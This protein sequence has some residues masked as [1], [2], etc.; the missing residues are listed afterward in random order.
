MVK[1]ELGAWKQRV[2]H[3][4]E[5]YVQLLKLALE[6]AEYVGIPLCIN[7]RHYATRRMQMRKEDNTKKT[8]EGHQWYR[9]MHGSLTEEAYSAR[10][11]QLRAKIWEISGAHHL[12]TRHLIVDVYLHAHCSA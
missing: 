9:L 11:G 4:E 3:D 10:L 12:K 5:R 7:I 6:W 8:N 1:K 2:V